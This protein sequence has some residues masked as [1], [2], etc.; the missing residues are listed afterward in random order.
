MDDN[1]YR[2][3]TGAE[4]ARD[5]HG[6]ISPQQARRSVLSETS[7]MHVADCLNFVILFERHSV[8]RSGTGKLVPA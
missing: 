1:P 4:S 8:W 5:F 7:L 3:S 6:R 2:M